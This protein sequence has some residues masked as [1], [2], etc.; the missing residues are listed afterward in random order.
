MSFNAIASNDSKYCQ[1]RSSIN[2]VFM[3]VY[4]CVYFVEFMWSVVSC[5]NKRCAEANPDKIRR[6]T[7]RNFVFFFFSF[8]DY[9]NFMNGTRNIIGLSAIVHSN[10]FVLMCIRDAFRIEWTTWQWWYFSRLSTTTGS[11]DGKDGRP[12]HRQ[13][14][15]SHD[16]YGG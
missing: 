7:E 8:S 3:Y 12:K 10:V 14:Y 9:T 1:S 2:F 13:R 11:N 15:Y 6:Y 16:T 4:L 5:Q